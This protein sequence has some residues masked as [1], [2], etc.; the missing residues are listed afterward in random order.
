MRQPRRRTAVN[1]YPPDWPAIAT[2]IK[3]AAGWQCVRCSHPHDVETCYVLTVHHLDLDKA[4][5][6]WWNLAA[7]CQRCHLSVQA[8]VVM[9]RPWMFEHSE[10]FKPYVAGYYAM[11]VLGVDLDRGAVMARL[12]ELLYLGRV[13]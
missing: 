2:A 7:L 13:A 11:T 1:D 12:E 3:D 8:R 9:E 6:R 4:N 10:W 5:C